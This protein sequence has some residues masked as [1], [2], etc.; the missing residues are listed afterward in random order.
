VLPND[1][2][3]VTLNTSEKMLHIGI[4]G[5]GFVGQA[6]AAA[7]NPKC[8][9]SIYDTKFSNTK[10]E[11]L[12]DCS[13]IF[14]CVPTNA[15]TGVGVAVYD[16]STLDD[17]LQQLDKLKYGGIV[18][19]K[20]TT[21]IDW[22]D[23][24]IKFNMAVVYCPEF[25]T[26]RNATTDFLARSRHIVGTTDD[27]LA[28]VVKTLY[29]EHGSFDHL[30]TI[31][32]LTPTEAAF[33]KIITNTALAVKVALAN[34]IFDVYLDYVRPPGAPVDASADWDKFI[35]VLTTNDP[36]LGTTHWSVPGHT[37]YGY[38][39]KCLPSSINH[40]SS[41]VMASG[42]PNFHN[43]SLVASEYNDVLRSQTEPTEY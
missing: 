40:F 32:R 36:R 35:S 8:Y 26:E 21:P 11:D 2:P 38:G 39:G 4:V 28:E 18:I 25:L 10:L 24:R 12:K 23:E 22:W 20:S 17:I 3:I 31:L 27:D 5:Y 15:T 41:L 13:V 30:V 37:G 42:T 1:Q 7:F 9:V 19:V 14:I 29:N 43:I 6:V 33:A 34:Q 16:T